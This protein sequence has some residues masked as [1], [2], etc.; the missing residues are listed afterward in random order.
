ML[1]YVSIDIISV[2]TGLELLRLSLNE[3]AEWLLVAGGIR[4]ITARLSRNDLIRMRFAVG[5]SMSEIARAFDISPQR[6][7][8]IVNFDDAL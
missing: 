5:E 1:L 3:I 8:Q 2:P 6:V 4:R 7:Y